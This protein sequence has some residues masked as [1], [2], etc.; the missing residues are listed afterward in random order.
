MINNFWAE[1]SNKKEIELKAI[2]SVENALK[3]LIEKFPELLAIYIKGSF[4]RREMIEES[5]IDIVPICTTNTEKY[6][7][8]R[9][10]AQN[11][12]EFKPSEFLP[13]SLEEFETGI[14]YNPNKELKGS[15][16]GTLRNLYQY[17]LVYGKPINIKKYPVRSDK[18]FLNGHIIAF[19][20]TFLPLLQK[21]KLEFKIVNK[22]IFYLVERELR[23]RGKKTSGKFT[24]LISQVNNKNHIINN[25]LEYRY[26]PTPELKKT[27]ISKLKTY[28]EELKK[29][30]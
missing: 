24:D 13:H 6:K 1:W 21:N 3:K 11:K 28:L 4:A 15:V 25:V 30:T 29:L 16:D 14:R 8:L 17:K 19:E 9:F 23:I 27:I 12:D 2:E 10:Q 26:N 22:Q 20:N 5:D 18:K 7:I